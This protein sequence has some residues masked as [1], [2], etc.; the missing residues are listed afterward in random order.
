MKQFKSMDDEKRGSSSAILSADLAQPSVME[1]ENQT[2]PKRRKNTKQ[3]IHSKNRTTDIDLTNR[4]FGNLTVLKRANEDNPRSDS[5]L[6]LC[7]CGNTKITTSNSLLSGRRKSCGC[8]YKPQRK[9]YVGKRFN[10]LTVLSY[11]EKRN[12]FHFWRCQCDCGNIVSVSQNNLQSGH[13]KSCGCLS[14]PV[15]TRHYFEGTCIETIRNYKKLPSNNTSGVRGVYPSKNR[16]GETLWVA[17][18]T[19][20]GVTKYLGRFK[21]IE[22]AAAARHEAEKV[23]DEV[24]ERFDA[25]RDS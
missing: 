8:G 13:S 19:F 4:R 10:K 6:C 5:W 22:E 20:K 1:T 14:D 18:I 3:Q 23:F 17:Q 15:S 24:L 2:K 7:D 25:Q 21:T 16:K 12:G 9:D 11:E